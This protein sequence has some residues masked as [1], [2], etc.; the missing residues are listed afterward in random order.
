MPD[1][2]NVTFIGMPGS[3][4]STIGRH[5]ANRLG[6]EFIDSDSIIED[7]V[8]CS[9]LSFFA[10]RGEFAFRKIEARLLQEILNKRKIVLATGGGAILLGRSRESLRRSS[11]VVYLK[12]E[13]NDLF[14]RLS[15]DTQRPLLQVKN[16]L[17]RLTE[18]FEVRNS[19][20]TETA[21]TIVMTERL[22]VRDLVEAILEKIRSSNNISL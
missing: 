10:L 8:G 4:K 15:Q 18:L 6:W 17:A 14:R 2:N 3:G 19:L 5:I 13:P 16:P 22:S 12:A 9:I 11:Y 20:Y 1:L 21:H 7:S